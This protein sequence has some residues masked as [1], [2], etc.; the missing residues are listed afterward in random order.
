MNSVRA[1][2]ILAVVSEKS[3]FLA[4]IGGMLIGY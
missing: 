4:R 2:V 1:P 3:K